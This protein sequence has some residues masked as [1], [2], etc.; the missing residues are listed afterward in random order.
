MGLLSDMAE[1]R[2]IRDA[3]APWEDVSAAWKANQKPGDP[4]LRFKRLL[5]SAAGS[6]NM[7]RTEYAPHH[8]E[9]PHSHPEDEVLFVLGGKLFFG[10]E[11]LG[12]G[13]AIFVPRGKVY[14]LRTEGT[15]A[16]FV[17]IG[18]GDYAPPGARE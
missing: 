4:G 18:F 9:A 17:R 13:D 6:P 15:G 2:L 11:E 12:F 5:P 8:H 10:R 3:D 14:S 16:Q 7:Q 1:I